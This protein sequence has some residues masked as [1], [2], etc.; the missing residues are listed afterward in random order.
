MQQIVD[1]NKIRFKQR[2]LQKL[3]EKG[4][5]RGEIVHHGHGTIR[6][7]SSDKTEQ[8]LNNRQKKKEAL[9]PEK[10]MIEK[11][12]NET[13]FRV[14]LQS[15]TP[16]S[17]TGAQRARWST[18]QTR[19][20]QTRSDQSFSTPKKMQ[21]SL[22]RKRS[23]ISESKV[24]EKLTAAILGYFSDGRIRRRVGINYE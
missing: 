24:L 4:V 11:K 9:L 6:V 5:D 2:V 22:R 18:T 17:P 14:H 1:Q 16:K 8:I 13:R 21:S 7:S 19:P 23:N 20:D 12:K 10:D 15:A 3:S